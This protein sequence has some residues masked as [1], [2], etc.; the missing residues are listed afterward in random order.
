MRHHFATRLAYNII[1]LNIGTAI[2]YER[3]IMERMSSS[4]RHSN[5][6]RIVFYFHN[7]GGSKFVEDKGTQEFE[8]YSNIYYWRKFIEYFL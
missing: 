6:T 2:P 4:C 7:K 3:P 1:F 5:V 8:T